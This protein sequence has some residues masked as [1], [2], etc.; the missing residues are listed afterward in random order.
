MFRNILVAL[1]FNQSGQRALCVA[2][3]MAQR[4][5]SGLTV[6]HALNYRLSGEDLANAQEDA[7][8][9][10]A[11]LSAEMPGIPPETSLVCQPGEPSM[12]ICRV[13]R[14][15]GAGLVVLGCHQAEKCLSRMDYTGMTIV[16][17]A[18]CPVLIVP[19]GVANPVTEPATACG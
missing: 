19:S 3:E 6:V 18:H 16:E 12:V 5:G 7:R 11:A 8:E 10:F 17:K 2:S 9:H 13:A 4:F 1:K 15:A 14:D